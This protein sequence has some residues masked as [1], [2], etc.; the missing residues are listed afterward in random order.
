[1]KG[2]AEEK[3]GG[4]LVMNLDGLMEAAGPAFLPHTVTSNRYT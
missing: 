2:V 4:Q 1:M 3:S